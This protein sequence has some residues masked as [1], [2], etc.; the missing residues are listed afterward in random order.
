LL[1]LIG[2]GKPE[3]APGTQAAYNNSGYVLLGYIIERLTRQSYA[4]ASQQRVL[5][6]A[7]LR[8]RYLLRE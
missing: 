4:Q 2:Q 6:K 3:F 8:D 5:R 1:H 7:C